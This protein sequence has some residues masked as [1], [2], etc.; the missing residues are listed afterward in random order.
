MDIVN[1]VF[2]K[3]S[4]WLAR[5][6]VVGSCK[7]VVNFLCFYINYICMHMDVYY[8]W[9]VKMVC[10]CYW[11]LSTVGNCRRQWWSSC[12]SSSTYSGDGPWTDER[13]SS[14]HSSLRF[15]LNPNYITCFDS[16]FA[17]FVLCFFYLLI[18]LILSRFFLV[19]W[20]RRIRNV[21][22]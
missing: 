14:L 2:L 6:N 5:L 1:L 17:L 15:V 10:F 9:P 20:V 19:L 16:S 21:P 22:G 11:K 12:S 18:S 4:P 7:Y 8:G 13:P 3:D